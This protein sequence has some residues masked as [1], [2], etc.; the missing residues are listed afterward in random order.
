MYLTGNDTGHTASRYLGFWLERVT[1]AWTAMMLIA[2]SFKVPSP[3]IYLLPAEIFPH[4]AP[5]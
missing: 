5:H 1:G 2:V 3:H 4:T